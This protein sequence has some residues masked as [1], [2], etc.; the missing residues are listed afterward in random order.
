MH[1]D[2]AQELFSDYCDGCIQPAFAVPL[3][4]HLAG[5]SQCRSEVDALRRLWTMLDEAPL[6]EPPAGFRAHVLNRL[7]EAHTVAPAKRAFDWRSLITRR[8]FAWTAVA[9]LVL[10]LGSVA[11]PGRYTS[12][13][14]G[15]FGDIFHRSNPA[16][17]V[18]LGEVVAPEG[19][20]SDVT[21]RLNV[22]G[23]GE[24]EATVKVLTGAAALTDD[25]RTI[26]LTPGK[27]A[28]VHLKRLGPPYGEPLRLELT[29]KDGATERDETLTVK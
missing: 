14:L 2:R 1:C 23:S 18:S 10:V 17:K 12:A 13:W 7:Q 21:V 28:E 27:P 6:V 8:A 19:V 26:S 16:L 22:T 4:S 9:I 3:E 11:I 24:S 29:W 5:C 15:S 20:N 25:S